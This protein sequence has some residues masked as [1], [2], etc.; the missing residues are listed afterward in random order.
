MTAYPS[1]LY[2]VEGRVIADDLVDPETGE[3]LIEGNQAL[4]SEMLE[5]IE[6]ERDSLKSNAL[7][8]MRLV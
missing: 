4:T 8:W 5:I 2:D 3:V 7:S 6:R 1:I